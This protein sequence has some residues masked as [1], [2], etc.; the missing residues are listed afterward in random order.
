M[1]KLRPEHRCSDSE[2]RALCLEFMVIFNLSFWTQMRVPFFSPENHNSSI[3]LARTSTSR[4]L[5]FSP[6]SQYTLDHTLTSHPKHVLADLWGHQ[7][8][9]HLF[10]FAHPF[11]FHRDTSLLSPSFLLALFKSYTF[12][13]GFKALFGLLCQLFLHEV[14]FH[15]SFPWIVLKLLPGATKSKQVSAVNCFLALYFLINNFLFYRNC[16]LP[17]A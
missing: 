1:V 11:P 8:Y 7:V 6:I 16:S 5:S 4:H 14:S 10:A 2:S 12:G 9:S 15:C 17:L 3:W 13:S